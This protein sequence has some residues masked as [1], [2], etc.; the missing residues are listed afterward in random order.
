MII[1]FKC[2]LVAVFSFVGIIN[3]SAQTKYV[4]EFLNIGVGA[5]AF[6]LGG[7]VVAS[8]KDVTSGYWNPAGLRKMPSDFQLSLMHS[9]YFGGLAKYDY[10]GLAYR[11][12]AN[13]GNLGIN[14]IR[15]AVDDIPYTL[16]LIK[17]DGSIDEGALTKT[18]SVADYAAIIGY[19][20][21]LRLK[22]LQERDDIYLSL[23][24]NV[25]IIHRQVSTFARAWGVG[26]DAGLKAQVKRWYFGA[27][28]R[29][30]STTYTGWS[31]SLTQKEKDV[32]SITGNE[33]P[34]TS[35]EIMNPRLTLGVARFIP[36]GNKNS[37]M[38]EVDLELTTDG[39]RY[40]YIANAGFLSVNTRAGVEFNAQNKYFI[41]GGV[42]GFQRIKDN[43]DT[44]NNKTV[45]LFQPAL[46]VGFYV[47]N[48]TIDYAFTSLNLQQNPLYTHVF[49][50]KM[51]LR[52]PKKFRKNTNSNKN[53]SNTN[54]NNK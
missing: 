33:I 29:D 11:L 52:K 39:T 28:L 4:N 15:F 14:I 34:L 17:P 23:G 21:D 24:A 50:L 30:A 20:K 7:A 37:M 51:D 13:K 40:G 16:N 31:F 45:L 8:T 12:G 35:G 25:K 1:R 5:R 26:L 54:S 2:A 41:R 48:I 49:G 36:I 3:S 10:A 38:P 46:G 32:F 42:Q 44:S 53:K 47:N 19:S 18:F 6:S 43:T 22:S 27:M 9:E